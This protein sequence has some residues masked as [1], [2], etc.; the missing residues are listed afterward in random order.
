MLAVFEVHKLDLKV[1][2]DLIEKTLKA[3][4]IYRNFPCVTIRLDSM[5]K[6]F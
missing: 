6:G 1:Q 4:D 2:N 5:N 3:L